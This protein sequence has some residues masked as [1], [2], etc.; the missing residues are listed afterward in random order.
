[1]I[2]WFSIFTSKLINYCSNLFLFFFYF[3]NWFFCFLF[4]F[5][6]LL[7][8]SLFCGDVMHGRGSYLLIMH[9]S[10]AIFCKI[11]WYSFLICFLFFIYY[12]L[13]I[14]SSYYFF[15]LVYYYLFL[16]SLFNLLYYFLFLCTGLVWGDYS[17]GFSLSIEFRFILL[18]LYIMFFLLLIFAFIYLDSVLIV[19]RLCIIFITLLLLLQLVSW[20]QFSSFM[21]AFLQSISLHGS[22]VEV[23]Q[24]EESLHFFLLSISGYYVS[25]IF[26]YV[27]YLFCIFFFYLVFGLLNIMLLLSPFNFSLYNRNSTSVKS[28][29]F[30][31]FNLLV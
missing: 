26:I 28:S 20:L 19:F 5:L 21:S 10:L 30:C 4:F 3:F 2:I 27:V 29:I 13:Y 23:H 24:S 8:S 22:R 31:C 6:F 14:Q 16:C 11:L 1:M 17:W 15:Y 7:N 25:L 12:F 18:F 9:S